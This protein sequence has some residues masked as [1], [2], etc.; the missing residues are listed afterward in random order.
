MKSA[1]II[2]LAVCFVL[3]VFLWWVGVRFAGVSF[4][5]YET[6]GAWSGVVW[7]IFIGFVWAIIL[8]WPFI[9]AVAG[10]FAGFY[11]PSDKNFR[12]R[13]EYSIAEAKRYMA[14]AGLHMRLDA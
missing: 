14:R 1:T 3:T 10:K 13:P 9:G 7:A 6:A 5:V 2:R 8:G 12:V 11:L 4:N